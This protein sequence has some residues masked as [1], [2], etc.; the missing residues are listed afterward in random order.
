MR[1]NMGRESELALDLR[2]T[3][4]SAL[5]T[6]AGNGC[7]MGIC[8]YNAAEFSAPGV[9]DDQEGFFVLEGSGEAELDGERLPV[10][11]GTALILPPG[12]RHSFR[13]HPNVPYLK[14][15]WFHAAP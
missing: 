1:M 12:V 11:A 7:C 2:Q 13:R 5:L 10:Q 4:P 9:H 8:L 3:N 15:L 14:V 6:A